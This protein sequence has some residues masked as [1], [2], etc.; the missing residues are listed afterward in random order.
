MSS[1]KMPIPSIDLPLPVGLVADRPV[2]VDEAAI[3]ADV[4]RLFDECADGLRRY[5]GAFG[6]TPAASEDIVQEAFLSLFRHLRLGRSRENLRGWLYRVVHN[7]AL[8]Q[9]ERGR[10]WM[11][12][13]ADTL[14][15]RLE[16]PEVNPEERLAA[17]QR[18]DRLRAVARALPERDRR[19]LYLRAEGLNYRD[20]AGTLGVSLG[21]VAKSLTRAF[22]R[23]HHSESR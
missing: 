21:S 14:A 18:R 7:L 16:D 5:A 2:D 11:S 8:K 19:C 22:A 17:A 10:R 6:L 23:L 13:E 1:P 15:I 9:R 3:Q 20:I 12:V 4:L